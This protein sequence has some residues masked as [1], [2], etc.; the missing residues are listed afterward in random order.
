MVWTFTAGLFGI[1]WIID[2]FLLPEF[3]EEHNSR[4]FHQQQLDT[5]SSLLFQGD[6]WQPVDDAGEGG[7]GL[8]FPSGAYDADANGGP[9]VFGASGATAPRNGLQQQQA[10]GGG[11]Y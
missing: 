7:Q 6:Y 5:G 2:A 11:Y 3:V 9:G 1:G 8:L 10:G 4:L